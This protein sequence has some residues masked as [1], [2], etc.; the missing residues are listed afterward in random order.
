MVRDSSTAK[1][2]DVMA[3]A[4]LPPELGEWRIAWFVAE[5]KI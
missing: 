3:T 2:T 4:M 5:R 1:T